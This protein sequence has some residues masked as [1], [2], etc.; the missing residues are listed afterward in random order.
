M[1]AAGLTT[2]SIGLALGGGAARGLAHIV[3][4]EALDELGVKPSFIAGCS[5]G[6]LLGAAYA[7]GLTG[8]EIREHA[9]SVLGSPSAAA[10]RLF[11]PGER[12]EKVRPINLGLF[13]GVSLNGLGLVRLVSP[14]GLARRVEDTEI[15][16][17]V[18]STDFYAGRE[19]TIDTGEMEQA[20]AAS[21]AIPGVIEAPRLNGRVM[22]DGAYTNPVPMDHVRER[23]CELLIA[24]DVTGKAVENEDGKA[25]GATEL[26]IGGT[27]IM[28]REITRLKAQ[29]A[30]PDVMIVPATDRFGAHEF[31][32]IREILAAAEPE[33]ERLKRN[34]SL[35]LDGRNG[36]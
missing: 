26:I 21:I 33:R 7:S 3:V 16:F 29:T 10:R 6:A 14:P 20:V 32:K 25:P 36:A 35:L 24:V 31:L 1:A 9:L 13:L 15:P 12:E 34:L 18:S 4:L 27:Q 19:V 28:Q 11:W 17:A 2:P 8:G 23:G 30:R 5:I 22:I